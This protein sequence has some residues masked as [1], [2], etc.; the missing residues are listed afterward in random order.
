M[1][2]ENKTLSLTSDDETNG[3]QPAPE[4]FAKGNGTIPSLP[5]LNSN[6]EAEQNKRKLRASKVKRADQESKWKASVVEWQKKEIERKEMELQ[7]KERELEKLNKELREKEWELKRSIYLK[8][9][10]EWA[11]K[12]KDG[13][14]DDSR[15]L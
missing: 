15:D 3:R 14:E 5:L 2:M 4:P 8:V 13:E 10:K 12:T 9:Y 1:A 6:W 11:R 7:S